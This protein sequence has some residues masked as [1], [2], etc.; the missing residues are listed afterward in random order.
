MQGNCFPHC[1]SGVLKPGRKRQ[2]LFAPFSKR[3]QCSSIWKDWISCFRNY[4]YC[5]DDRRYSSIYPEQYE[6]M[7]ELKQLFETNEQKGHA[8]IEMPTGTGKTVCI[9]SVYLAAKFVNPRM[10]RQWGG[11][12]DA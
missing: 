2:S 3:Q 8:L 1:L 11:D 4:P 9:F 5:C 7:L 6:Y 12:S 10:G